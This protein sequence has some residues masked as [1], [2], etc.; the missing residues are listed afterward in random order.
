ML[1]SQ[2]QKRWLVSPSKCRLVLSAAPSL[3]P[4]HDSPDLQPQARQLQ[5]KTH[6][7]TYAKIAFKMIDIGQEI[8]PIDA[9][10]STAQIL[11]PEITSIFPHQKSTT[12]NHYLRRPVVPRASL[13]ERRSRSQ[14]LSAPTA[15]TAPGG[16][17]LKDLKE[18]TS[19]KNRGI[20]WFFWYPMFLS[21]S[22]C[23]FIFFIWSL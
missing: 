4:A 1:A 12:R 7:Q 19:A 18:K 2:C 3:R 8:E 5:Q 9:M 16:R 21:P 6:G 23:F 22:I 11:T 14:A 13:V 20:S 17:D 15:P 10:D